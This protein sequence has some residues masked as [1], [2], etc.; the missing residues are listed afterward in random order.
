MMC[1]KR[2]CA[3]LGELGG[4]KA[5]EALIG[6][7][8]DFPL[9]WTAAEALGKLGEPNLDSLRQGWVSWGNVLA[10]DTTYLR[11]QIRVEAILHTPLQPSPFFLRPFACSAAA[12]Y[13]VGTAKAAIRRTMLPSSRP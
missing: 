4:A 3:A 1:A 11:S 2:R 7:L 10:P 5:V 13:P 6:V 8:D 12:P 9:R